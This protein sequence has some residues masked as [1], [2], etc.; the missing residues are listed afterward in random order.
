MTNYLV[1]PAMHQLLRKENL[2]GCEIGVETGK[3]AQNLFEN[4]SI[5]MLYLIDAYESYDGLDVDAHGT[6]GKANFE[7]AISKLRQYEGKFH[8]SIGMSDTPGVVESIPNNLDFLYIDGNHFY[9]FVKKD[10][11]NYVPKVKQGGVIGGHDF[12]QIDVRK[13]VYEYFPH[14]AVKFKNCLD[15]KAMD[16]WVVI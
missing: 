6:D 5:Q 3:H 1:R 8:F 16:W 15:C 11:E 4:L 9:E 13:A 7:L 2:V 14:S 12:D 10:L